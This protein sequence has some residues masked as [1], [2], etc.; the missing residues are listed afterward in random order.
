LKNQKGITLITLVIT[1]V[2]LIIITGVVTYNGVETVNTSQKTA[3]ISELEMIQAKVNV[4]YEERKTSTEK[5]KYYN[6]IGQDISSVDQIRV[7]EA[8]GELNKDG[9]KFFDPN[10]L[11]K[12]DL[13]NINQEVLINYDTR[14][15][16]SL[17]GYK[18][19]GIKYYK[20]KDIPNYIGY[21]VEYT[22]KNTQAPEFTITKTKLN[23]NE[24]RLTIKDI[25]YNSNVNGGTVSYKLHS[26]TN[27]VLNGENTN[28]I[29][30][31]PGLYDIKFTDKVGNETIKQE[32]IHE[33]DYMGK[34]LLAYYD[35]ENN[36]GNGHSNNTRIWKDLSGNN[37]DAD[38]ID[39]QFDD[40]SG[41]IEKAI[42]LSGNGDKVIF[43]I[44][45]EAAGTL[46]VEIVLTNQNNSML[47]ILSSDKG[48]GAF[49]AHIWENG[50]IYIGCSA[51]NEGRLE[52]GDINFSIPLNKPILLTYT[53]DDKS[54]IA[55]L[56]INGKKMSNKTYNI[57]PIGIQSFYI[58]TTQKQ[59]NR[60]NFYNQ[61]LTQEE[62][63]N[64]YEIDKY[65]FGITE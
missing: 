22:N 44:Q 12:L 62:I 34:G 41:W 37:K 53:Y 6:L 20:L 19:D 27:W 51:Y 25:V 38:L 30:T 65:R 58:F 52:P 31:K 46:S 3:F 29:I 2:I 13:N 8:L 39:F 11:K 61:V 10:D 26:D 64:N 5:V 57:D 36:T 17:N 59:F 54:R 16:V 50:K 48:W 14:E 40:T 23:D 55:T 63:Q 60:I 18:I 35:G 33:M 9:F 49:N 24:Y 28:F 7:N 21:N 47:A 43:P 42:Q 56:Y 15:V 45:I 32:F 4:I 1:I